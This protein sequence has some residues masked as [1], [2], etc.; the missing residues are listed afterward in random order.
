MEIALLAL[1][2]KFNVDRDSLLEKMPEQMEKAFDSRKKMMATFHKENG[3]YRIAVKGAPE[4]VLDVCSRIGTE[5]GKDRDL[6][7]ED[8]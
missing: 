5:N 3:S 8:I 1:G 4:A 6:T 7:K 2:K